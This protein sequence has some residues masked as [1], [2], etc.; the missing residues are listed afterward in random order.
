LATGIAFCPRREQLCTATDTTIQNGHLFVSIWA[1]ELALIAA[2]VGDS[3]LFRYK[4]FLPFFGALYHFQIR[5]ERKIHA[6]ACLKNAES[7][8]YINDKKQVTAARTRILGCR[9]TAA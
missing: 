3:K 7:P 8:K 5:F 1:T 9:K 4:D 6:G 2:R